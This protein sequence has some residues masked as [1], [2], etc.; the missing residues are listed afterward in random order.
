AAAGQDASEAIFA[1]TRGELCEGTGTNVFIARGGRLMTPPLSSGC[2]AGITRALVLETTAAAT[3]ATVAL[4]A[5]TGADEAF[6]T[7]S[8]REVQPIAA[9]DGRPLPAAPGPLTQAAMDAYAD[10]LARDLDP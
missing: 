10:L 8:T 9:V 1:N 2:L 4:S 5:L 6:L 7:S 3:E